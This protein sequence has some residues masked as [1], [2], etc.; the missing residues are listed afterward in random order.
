MRASVL[1][2]TMLPASLSIF[3]IALTS[4]HRQWDAN[5]GSRMRWV[6]ARKCC[7][8]LTANGCK[9][10]FT[11]VRLD[12]LSLCHN[13]MCSPPRALSNGAAGLSHRVRTASS[14][15]VGSQ[16]SLAFVQKF[17][18]GLWSVQLRRLRGLQ[19]ASAAP[20]GARGAAINRFLGPAPE[21]TT[22]MLT[23][24]C[25]HLLISRS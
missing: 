1:S 18:G 10:L 16:K 15:S 19:G 2:S 21:K 12:S 13:R 7:V 3:A 11:W 6:S 4:C 23:A 17:S 9:G 22:V 20:V 14:D 24:L 8:S 25:D 5:N